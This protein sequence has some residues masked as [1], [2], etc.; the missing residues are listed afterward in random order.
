M[1]TFELHE[2]FKRRVGGHCFGVVKCESKN[3][4]IE[5]SQYPVTFVVCSVWIHN[6]LFRKGNDKGFHHP[7]TLRGLC[8]NTVEALRY[9]L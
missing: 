6:R 9:K 2:K 4:D 3:S 7:Y 8:G 5:Y 1:E